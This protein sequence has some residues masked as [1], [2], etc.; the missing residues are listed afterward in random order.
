MRRYKRAE[1]VRDLLHEEVS[2]ILQRDIKDPR[3]DLVIITRVEL[4]EDL[5]HAK[6]YVTSF[7]SEEKRKEVLAGLEKASGYIRGALG[8]RLNLKFI[9][10]IKF[11]FDE[12]LEETNRVL[13]L[14][15][16]VS[17]EFKV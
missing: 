17:P 15:D 7:G 10:E 9:P 16:E 3:I 12:S 6:F 4:S 1:R 8:K 14:I 11:I 2:R 13:R 5:K